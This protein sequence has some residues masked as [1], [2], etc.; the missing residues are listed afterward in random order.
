[1][2]R[3][4]R[5]FLVVTVFGSTAAF[6]GDCRKTGS[7]CADATPVKLISGVAVNVADVGGC[8]EYED[9]YGDV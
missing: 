2:L 8:W 5:F 1:M 3:W 6:A 9:T 4:M 7:V